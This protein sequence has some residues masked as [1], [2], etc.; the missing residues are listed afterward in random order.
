M[1][2]FYDGTIRKYITQTIRFFSNFVVKYNDGTLHRIPVLYGDPSKQVASILRQNSENSLNSVPRISVYI[3]EL[4]LDRDRMGD[5][6]FVSSLHV[7]ERG[8][9]GSGEYN[10]NAGRNYT[11]ERLMPTPYNLTM[12]VDIWAANT[13][14]KLQILEQILVF[15]NPSVEIQSS[16]NFIDWT[17]L[18]VLNLTDIKWSSR[19]IPVGTNIEIDVATLTLDT[20]IWISP[21]VKVK[22][23]GVITNIISNIT[24]SMTNYTSGYIEG[25]GIDTSD[26]STLIDDIISQVKTS[27]TD[28]PILVLGNTIQLDVPHNNDDSLIPETNVTST[29]KWVDVINKYPGTLVD[30]VSKIYL[31]QTNGT[32]IIG[33]VSVNT[34]DPSILLVDWDADTFEAN[35]GIDSNGRLDTD[36]TY[37][38]STSYRP[39]STGT[40]D[41]IINPHTYNPKRPNNETTDQPIVVGTRFLLTNDIGNIT[42]SNGA[43]AWKSNSGDDLYANTYD[44]I[45]WTGETWHV[46]FSSSTEKD[47]M[48]WQTNIH[49]NIQYLWNGAFWAKSF[50]RLYT[51][52]E[53]ELVL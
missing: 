4:K 20:P 24:T 44:I 26:G 9:S 5:S 11:V 27:I 16:D 6:S 52:G 35:T 46:I 2:F 25:L 32:T 34:N 18:S 48:I 13:E 21:P 15:F 29:K 8:I 42:N 38:A 53:W 22:Q 39:S 23:L 28:Y 36:L 50:D 41:A 49:T 12:K 37:D 30:G 45:E 47:T 1:Q 17:S 14:Q 10:S 40:I 31:K 7:R 51:I 33:A 3:S 19:T 43:H